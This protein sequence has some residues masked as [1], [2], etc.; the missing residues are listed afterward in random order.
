[1]SSEKRESWRR[2]EDEESM[3][4]RWR[5][6]RKRE[7]KKWRGR[8]G[9]RPEREGDGERVEEEERWGRK[10][11]RGRRNG[12]EAEARI[13]RERNNFRCEKRESKKEISV[14]TEVSEKRGGKEGVEEEE[15]DWTTR[16]KERRGRRN[17]ALLL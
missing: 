9:E 13:S 8:E 4:E 2:E 3:V 1:M 11:Q 15:K 17:L 7:E 6:G 16:R 14:A 5:G 12:E 10:R